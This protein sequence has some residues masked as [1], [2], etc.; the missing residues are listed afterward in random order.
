MTRRSARREVA[1]PAPDRGSRF[2]RRENILA[3]MITATPSLGP[4]SEIA[5]YLLERVIGRGGMGV[6]WRAHQVALDRPV[7]LKIVAPE[8]SANGAFRR[9]FEREARLAARLRHPHVVV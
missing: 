7:A 6:V 4:G 1:A 2:Q 3:G 9:R 8:L 5:G